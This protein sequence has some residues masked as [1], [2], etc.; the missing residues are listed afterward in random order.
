MVL[1]VAA[2]DRIAGTLCLPSG[3]PHELQVLVHGG[4]Y[5]RRYWSL[6][7]PTTGQSYV[8]GMTRAGRAT[9]A[10]DRIGVS[11]SSRPATIDFD[12]QVRT[13]HEV[14]QQL[15]GRGIA[16]RIVGV[17]HSFGSTILRKLA[18]DHPSAVDAL[19]LTGEAS[20]G[21]GEIDWPRHIHPATEDPFLRGYDER[22]YTTR[23]G[24]RAELFAHLP[25]A[26]PVALLWDEAA[27]QA[28][29]DS[30]GWLPPEVNAGITVPVL[31]VVGAHDKLLCGTGACADSATLQRLEQRWYP[32][33]TVRAVVIPETGHSITVH[34]GL[35]HL[36]LAVVEAL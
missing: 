16:D 35:R 1:P 4:T 27:K 28:D 13:V 33:T 34:R 9:F 20:S 32:R 6:H 5:D 8:D 7:G 24:R 18:V 36:T 22:Y 29:V 11:A 21:E 12:T 26:D 15:R 30:G 31:V 23:P 25:G 17:G 14:V 10:L 3:R 19:V 2:A